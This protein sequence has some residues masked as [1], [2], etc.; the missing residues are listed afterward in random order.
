MVDVAFVD[1]VGSV[2]EAIAAGIRL[3]LVW[4]AINIFGSR[5]SAFEVAPVV[6]SDWVGRIP[7]VGIAK[8]VDVSLRGVVCEIIVEKCVIRAESQ[9]DAI[10]VPHHVV[11]VHNVV[12]GGVP[13]VDAI[14]VPR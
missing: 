3:I 7:E 1:L 6:T 9:P 5:V 11:A 4:T 2:P 13:K 10:L 14:I 8:G 12:V